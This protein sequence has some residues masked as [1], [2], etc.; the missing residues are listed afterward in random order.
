M[1]NTES[2]VSVYIKDIKICQGAAFGFSLSYS[3]Y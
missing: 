3:A 1:E 2:G